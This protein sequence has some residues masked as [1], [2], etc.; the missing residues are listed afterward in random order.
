MPV[1]KIVIAYDGTDWSGW[2]IQPNAATIQ[3]ELERILNLLLK[4]PTRVIGAGRT[5]A[6]VHAMGQTAHFRTDLLLSPDHLLRSLNG[7]LPATIRVMDM[8]TVP[9][10]FHAQRSAQRKIYHYHLYLRPTLDPFRRG[11]VLFVRDPLN[12][13]LLK[14][15][16]ALF[17]GTHDF[18]SFSNEASRGAASR[19][20]IRTLYRVDVVEEEGGVR[21]EF[22]GNGFLYKM[23][24]NIVG[25]VLDVAAG[26]RAL[27]EIE[28]IFEAKDRKLA[29]RAAPACGLFL[30]HVEYPPEQEVHSPEEF[31]SLERE[32][33]V[34][35][36]AR[37]DAR[38]REHTQPLLK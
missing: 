37:M 27:E 34:S 18:T 16:A 1:Y 11:K 33:K 38:Q 15:A 7:I 14:Q 36:S 20:A 3:G 6:G 25:T 21:L 2:Q 22:E 28:K 23:V 32:Q 13:P 9:P 8:A 35:G 26:K 19:N 30:M 5:D 12:L 31:A 24:R 10:T 17:V 4:V 29:S